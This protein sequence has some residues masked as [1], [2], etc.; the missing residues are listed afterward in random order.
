MDISSIARLT[1]AY[2]YENQIGNRNVTSSN[3]ADALRGATTGSNE[4]DAYKQHLQEKFG[5]PI[6]VSAIGS[7]QNSMDR[8]GAGTSGTGNVV[9]APNILEQMASDPEK[10]AK[11]EKMIQEHFDSLPATEAFMAS[12]GH[13]ITSCGVVIHED[14]TAHYYLS[15]EEGPEIKAKFEAAQKAKREKK[16]K[17]QQEAAERSRKAAEE[18][19]MQREQ[20]YHRQNMEA[21][22]HT[23]FLQSHNTCFSKAIQTLDAAYLS[24]ITTNMTANI[25]S[26]V[27]L[28]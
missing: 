9:I 17:E 14:G 23:Q 2:Q 10:A 24:V 25:S 12:I 6:M 13:K 19:A 4:V 18:R 26:G 27:T 21:L 3:F 1:G 11:Y 16:I 20:A 15:G 5:V 22:L 8:L 28:L 7:D